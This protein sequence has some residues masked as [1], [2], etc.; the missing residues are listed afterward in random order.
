MW[1]IIDKLQ[2]VLKSEYLSTCIVKEHVKYD[3]IT[4]L[5][6]QLHWLS[7]EARIRH[8]IAVL[9]FMVVAAGKPSYITG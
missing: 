1:Y 2:R 5:L 9:T 6:S 4:P 8:K 7:I 3:H